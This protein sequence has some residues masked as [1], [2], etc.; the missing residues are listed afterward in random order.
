MNVDEVKHDNN[1]DQVEIRFSKDCKQQSYIEIIHK[2]PTQ[3]FSGDSNS[4]TEEFSNINEFLKSENEEIKIKTVKPN[5]SPFNKIK[6]PISNISL[7]SFRKVDTANT[8]NLFD[9]DR[10]PSFIDAN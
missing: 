5:L 7:M 4:T 10:V 3:A 9:E 1:K 8:I 2:K 6:E